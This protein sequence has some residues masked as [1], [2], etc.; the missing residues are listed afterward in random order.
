ME[1]RYLL[2]EIDAISEELGPL[3]Y[4]VSVGSVH[5][6]DLYGCYPW[7]VNGIF[8]STDENVRLQ[9]LYMLRTGYDALCI[10]WS[11]KWPDVVEM[12]KTGKSKYFPFFANQYPLGGEWPEGSFFSLVDGRDFFYYFVVWVR[13]FLLLNDGEMEIYRVGEYSIYHCYNFG[14]F[15]S[16]IDNVMSFVSVTQA[17]FMLDVLVYIKENTNGDGYF[18]LIDGG[19]SFG[20]AKNGVKNDNRGRLMLN[21]AIEKLALVS[22]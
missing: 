19:G 2:D 20:C 3:A 14:E 4:G 21:S 7:D 1:D 12:I 10:A 11:G 6:F 13:R 18:G 22:K 17:K 15:L 5:F 9:Y 16:C 8:S